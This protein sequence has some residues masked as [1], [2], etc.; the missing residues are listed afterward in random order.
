M[1][2]LLDVELALTE[3]VPQLDGLVAGSGDDLT[4]VGG[5]GDRE[6]IV[7]VANE[8]AGGVAGVEVPET[9]G[10]VPGGGQSELTVGGDDNILDGRV[11]AAEGL[12]GDTEVA[13]VIAGQ[14]PDDDGL[15]C[16]SNEKC[17]LMSCLLNVNSSI[18]ANPGR[19]DKV[20]QAQSTTF[21]C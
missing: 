18:E 10:L 2:I 19:D 14:G 6:D 7:G 15:V 12:L 4:V 5:E 13:L 21:G 11:V 20:L 9:E 8:A 17:S 1:A 16:K 3:G